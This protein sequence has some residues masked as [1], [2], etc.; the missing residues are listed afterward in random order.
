MLLAADA[1][2]SRFVNYDNSTMECHSNL[3]VSNTGTVTS[4]SRAG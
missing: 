4:V 2:L 3:E 1:L